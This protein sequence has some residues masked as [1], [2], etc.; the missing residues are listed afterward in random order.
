MRGITFFQFI[1]KD[2]EEEGLYTAMLQEDEFGTFWSVFY[3]EEEELVELDFE[4]SDVQEF[5][6]S[7]HWKIEVFA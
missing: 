6:M 3:Y 4:L 1:V 2:Y 5:I 7:D